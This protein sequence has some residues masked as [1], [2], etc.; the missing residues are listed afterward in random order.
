VRACVCVGGRVTVGR[1]LKGTS[2]WP[3]RRV[4]A[5]S[6]TSS[7]P[8]I[9]ASPSPSS[10]S[11]SRA[12]SVSPTK[13]ANAAAAAS[14][15]HHSTA[16]SGEGRSRTTR[17]AVPGMSED[18]AFRRLAERSLRKERQARRTY[19]RK[20]QYTQVELEK[21]KLLLKAEQRKIR[22]WHHTPTAALALKCLLLAPVAR[23]R[24]PLLASLSVTLMTRLVITLVRAWRV[25]AWRAGRYCDRGGVV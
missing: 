25:Q 12:S 13:A 14:S 16:P 20:Q 1:Y 11:P 8:D 18:G 2:P 22:A 10:S 7:L 23:S 3:S 17:D 9:R 21:G 24:T 6:S 19:R 15:A 5:G 4:R